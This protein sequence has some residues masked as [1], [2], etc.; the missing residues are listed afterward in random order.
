[1][2]DQTAQMHIDKAK[3]RILLVEQAH[4][5]LDNI[6][7]TLVFIVENIKNKK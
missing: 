7:S 5:L 4:K 2:I 1:M 3:E 6:E